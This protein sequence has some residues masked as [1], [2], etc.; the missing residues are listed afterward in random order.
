MAVCDISSSV[1]FEVFTAVTMKNAVLWDVAPCRSCVNR[2]FGGMYRLHLQ[3]GVCSHLLMLVPRSRIFLPWRRRRYVPPKRRFTQDLHGTRA[4]K[5][6]FFI[7]YSVSFLYFPRLTSRSTY[8][9]A[10][11]ALSLCIRVRPV[12][13]HPKT[14]H[15]NYL[16]SSSHLSRHHII[17]VAEIMSGRLTCIT[18]RVARQ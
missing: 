5:T 2:R 12:N 17:P 4:Q 18:P 6:T 15:S 13:E 3:A 16:R 10:T 11:A 1:R 9:Q 14:L 8:W 7:S